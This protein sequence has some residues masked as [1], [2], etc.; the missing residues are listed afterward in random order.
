MSNKTEQPDLTKAENIEAFLLEIPNDGGGG[1]GSCQ[2]DH[3]DNMV[4]QCQKAKLPM[5]E[6]W[7]VQTFAD[8]GESWRNFMKEQL[9]PG[10]RRYEWMD[11]Y[12]RETLVN[13][14]K[15]KS[16]DDALDTE[17][18]SAW[19]LWSSSVAGF[20][21][22]NNNTDIEM[23]GNLTLSDDYDGYFIYL[24]IEYGGVSYDSFSGFD[25]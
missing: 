16:W 22:I 25:T 8:G 11:E 9:K 10:E 4:T 20:V 5:P 6:G 7:V 24:A 15:A 12:D 14:N 18:T 17:R 21:T 1:L 3:I 13:V 19:D 23:W 2:Y